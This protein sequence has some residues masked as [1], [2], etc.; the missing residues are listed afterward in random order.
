M[1]ICVQGFTMDVRFCFYGIHIGLELLNLCFMFETLRRFVPFCS[2]VSVSGQ[3]S[4]AYC[5]ATFFTVHILTMSKGICLTC[6]RWYIS[7][8]NTVIR[9]AGSSV[10]YSGQINST[11]VSPS[12]LPLSHIFGTLLQFGS[13]RMVADGPAV[14]LLLWGLIPTSW[15]VFLMYLFRFM[16]HLWKTVLRL[17]TLT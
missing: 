7:V 10:V 9:G 1:N 15:R 3:L 4:V 12:F 5:W 6:S 13:H 16:F 2:F 11:S 8:S 14:W 17:L